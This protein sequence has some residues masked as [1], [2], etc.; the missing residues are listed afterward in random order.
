MPS[1][2]IGSLISAQQGDHQLKHFYQG[3]DSNAP[4]M[5]D[6][7]SKQHQRLY[8]KREKKDDHIETI[9]ID[10]YNRNTKKRFY[11]NEVIGQDSATGK[12]IICNKEFNERGNLQVHQRVHTGEK[13]YSC[14]FCPKRFTT[15]G[16]RND[17]ERRHIK[18]KP[19]IC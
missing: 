11:C 12:N 19:Y 6:A 5:K 18:D 9:V 1:D 13:P 15:I 8:K 2:V 17:H 10:T 4:Q 7:V 3:S 16:N 14:Q